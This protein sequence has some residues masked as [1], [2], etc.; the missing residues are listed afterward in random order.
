VN[1]ELKII[2][3]ENAG[4]SVGGGGAKV[5]G[6]K[7]VSLVP[8]L[9]ATYSEGWTVDTNTTLTF[10]FPSDPNQDSKVCT[11]KEELDPLGFSRWLADTLIGIS[12]VTDISGKGTPERKLVYDANFG[13]TYGA[14]ASL[15]VIPL[16]GLP[17]T[18]SGGVSR[19]DV[20]HLTVTI[21]A[22]AEKAAGAAPA[23]NLFT[24]KLM[25]PIGTTPA[26]SVR[27]M[28]RVPE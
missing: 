22:P 26:I 19:N 27:D 12:R 25:I 28:R 23:P 7:G 1:L 10:L 20:Q 2:S 24:Q 13:V 4:L 11:A 17:V 3:S 16:V 21:P 14:S 5:V 6:W 8:T 15:T 9:G 18:P